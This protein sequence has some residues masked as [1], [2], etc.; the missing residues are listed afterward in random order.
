MPAK[1]FPGRYTADADNELTV[2][3]IGIRINRWWAIHK[4]LPVFLAMPPMIQE[5]YVHKETG[6]LSMENFFSFRSTLM[7]QYWRSEDDLL[8]YSRGTKHVKAWKSFNQKVKN[9]QAV[10][11]Y[12]ETFKVTDGQFES[13]YVNMPVFGMAKAYQHVPVVNETA[14]ARQRMKKKKDEESRVHSHS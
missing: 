8:S 6:F 1:I 7:L 3:I 2:F 9:N 10:G 4:W 11:I 14:T 13:I 5:L 12:H